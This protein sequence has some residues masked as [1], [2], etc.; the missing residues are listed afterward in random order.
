MGRSG[1]DWLYC[2]KNL[3]ILKVGLQV[4]ARIKS[5]KRPY[6][7]TKIPNDFALT[8]TFSF[9]INTYLILNT[10]E[11]SENYSNYQ[12]SAAII[13]ATECLNLVLCVKPNEA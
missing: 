6:F 12:F 2:I 9:K 7:E 8:T 13:F 4:F 3:R 1:C 10:N 5:L 11:I